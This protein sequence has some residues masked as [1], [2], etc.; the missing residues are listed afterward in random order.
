MLAGFHV[1]LIL[2]GTWMVL[3]FVLSSKCSDRN[4]TN[5]R[6]CESS[7]LAVIVKVMFD[8]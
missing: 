3:E 8:Y 1:S 6:S 7:K 5:S 4:W 2:N